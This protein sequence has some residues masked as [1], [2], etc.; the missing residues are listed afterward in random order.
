MSYCFGGRGVFSGHEI[1]SD[2]ADVFFRFHVILFFT[3]RG[4]IAEEKYKLW[5]NFVSSRHAW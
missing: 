4:R 2:F 1:P 3:V 5:D